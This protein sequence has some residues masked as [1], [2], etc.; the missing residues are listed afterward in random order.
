MKQRTAAIILCLL[1]TLLLIA[2]LG[3]ILLPI[4][5]HGT[6]P[7]STVTSSNKPS[8]DSSIFN[9]QQLAIDSLKSH[10]TGISVIKGGMK[11]YPAHIDWEDTANTGAVVDSILRV[12]NK[13]MKLLDSLRRMQDRNLKLLRD[14]EEA[15]YQEKLRALDADTINL[16]PID[17][18]IQPTRN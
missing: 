12:Q 13:T 6:A 17:T 10:T 3:R 1:G 9:A 5:H 7:T 8:Y 18:L 16:R 4:Q 14:R 2:I 11:E 15:A